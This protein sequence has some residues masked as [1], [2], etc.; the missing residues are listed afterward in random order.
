VQ[1]PK[2]SRVGKLT[3]IQFESLIS[4]QAAPHHYLKARLPT[5]LHFTNPRHLAK[6]D[7]ENRF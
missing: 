6:T 7:D 2:K 1:I 4:K 5:R 3:A